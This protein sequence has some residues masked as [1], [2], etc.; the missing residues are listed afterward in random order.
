MDFTRSVSLNLILEI[1]EESD[2]SYTV[3]KSAYVSDY[4]VG[5]QTLL[6]HYITKIT[7]YSAQISDI[8]HG[9]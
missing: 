5:L 4:R 3:Y 9:L 2:F 8:L 1:V 6:L 7:A